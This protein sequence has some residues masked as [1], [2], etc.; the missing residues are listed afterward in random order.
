MQCVRRGAYKS[1]CSAYCK[2][3]SNFLYGIP[4]TGCG[5]E[6]RFMMN[7]NYMKILAISTASFV[8]TCSL[9][10]LS[11][12]AAADAIGNMQFLIGSEQAEVSE[13]GDPDAAPEEVENS[14]PSNTGGSGATCG[15]EAVLPVEVCELGQGLL[16]LNSPPFSVDGSDVII[17]GTVDKRTSHFSHIRVYVQHEYTRIFNEVEIEDWAQSDCWEDGWA[18]S[19]NGCL[20]ADGFF[21]IK[22]P[23]SQFGPYTVMIDAVSLDGEA[24]SKTV[25][26]SRVVAPELKSTDIKIDPDPA[27]VGPIDAGRVS[28]TVDLLHGCT[29]CDFIGIATGGLMVTVTNTIQPSGGG[30]AVVER[31]GN[32][33]AGG[34]FNV[35]V[36]V[37]SGR[38]SISVSACNAAADS[39][40]PAANAASLDAVSSD[41]S[42]NIVSPSGSELIWDQSKT[43]KIP[44][45][46]S[47]ENYQQPGGSCQNGDVVINWNRSEPVPLCPESDGFYYAQL[48]PAIGI[49]VG[50]IDVAANG[51]KISKSFSLGYGRITNPYKARSGWVDGGVGLHVGSDLINETVRPVINDFLNSDDLMEVV[52]EIF[53]GGSGAVGEQKKRDIA[54]ITKEI[55]FCESKNSLS[56]VKIK[57]IGDPTLEIADL[58]RLAFSN[59]NIGIKLDLKDFNVRFQVFRDDNGDDRPDGSILPVLVSF[60]AVQIDG[61]IELMPDGDPVILLTSDHNNCDFI[62]GAYCSKKP[63]LLIPSNIVGG[64]TRGGHFVRCDDS[65]QMLGQENREACRDLNRVNAQTGALSLNILNTINDLLYCQGSAQLTYAA[66]KALKNIKKLVNFPGGKR[67]WIGAGFDPMKGRLESSA[68]GIKMIVPSRFGGTDIL[69]SLD[70]RAGGNSV[71]ILV[72]PA[73]ASTDLLNATSD[74]VSISVAV[75]MINQLLFQ[76]AFQKKGQ[77]ILDWNIDQIFFEK[78]GFD[79]VSRCDAFDPLTSEADK[80][81]ALCQLRPRVGELLGA[82]LTTSGYFNAKHPLRM[83][84]T[85]SRKIAPHL[86]IYYADVPY[87][88]PPAEGEEEVKVEYRPAQ[89]VELAVPDLELAFYALEVDEAAGK[90]EYGNPVIRRGL[91]GNPTI[92]SMVEGSDSPVPII[93]VKTTLVLALEVS[94]LTTSS[95]DPSSFSINVRPI[96]EF[97]KIVFSEIDGGNST[98]VSDENLLS[99][100]REKI[101]YGIEI[102]GDPEKPI[103]LKIPKTF[104]LSSD[105]ESLLAKLGLGELNFGRDGLTL[106]FDN[107]YNRV[108]LSFKPQFE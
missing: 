66:R 33:A 2:K 54:N 18:A 61:K 28:V 6:V 35:C 56:G 38:N 51:G 19:G 20:D 31:K 82:A 68:S 7:H 96:P 60:K 78:F 107:D 94:G 9:L 5:H 40:C 29:N 92:K 16:C 8:A 63:A 106:D 14:E 55:P 4:I 103:A 52:A 42:I 70:E 79:F 46:F 89:V 17:K 102:Y 93:R 73:S 24:V 87:E 105:K 22:V 97:T 49:N 25:R 84:L 26:T 91:K 30:T 76:L 62:S 57:L 43:D 108:D 90:D 11:G 83:Q 77:G 72:N 13:S 104:S 37:M 86:N 74:S 65:G 45:K 67:V 34:I 21:A 58:E 3:V 41:V 47:I 69:S 50:T 15:P 71:G 12:S 53:S 39:N 32:I 75:D 59:S 48:I 10:F 85:G 80:P 1:G 100:F 36:P 95:D 81:P 88:L 44:L 27:S 99:A 101:T 98:I 23:L 64:A